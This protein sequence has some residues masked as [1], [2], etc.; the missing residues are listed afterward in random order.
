MSRYAHIYLTDEARQVTICNMDSV[1]TWCRGS[2][3]GVQLPMSLRCIDI[4]GPDGELRACLGDW[5]VCSDSDVFMVHS[6]YTFRRLYV[7]EDTVKR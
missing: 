2:I 1:A 6:N 4:Q 5:I 3:K 7:Q